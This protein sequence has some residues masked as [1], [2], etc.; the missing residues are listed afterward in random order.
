MR[1]QPVTTF[2]PV[3]QSSDCLFTLSPVPTQPEV[4]SDRDPPCSSSSNSAVDLECERGVVSSANTQ[5][6]IVPVV[7][8]HPMVTRS[9]AGIFKPK[10][11]SVEAVE[12]SIIE[13]ALTS[14]ERRAAVQAEYDALIRNSTWELVSRP[15]NRKVIG[16]KWL[17]KIK[18]NPDGTV[19]RKKAR[20]VAKGCSQILGCDFQETFSPVV[21]PATVR[22]VLSIAVS[23]GW[24]LRQVD[25]NNAF[26]NGDLYT[27][28]F[29]HQPPGYE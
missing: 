15:Q 16:C 7:N 10:V 19:A 26:L 28:V 1:N 17:F 5:A 6:P 29:M 3:V 4:G 13:E 21:K 20:L 24:Q 8:A 14:F 9:K 23:R 22:V 18:R 27:E 11:M 2:V 12:P 25:V